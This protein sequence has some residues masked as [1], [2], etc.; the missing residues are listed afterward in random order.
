MKLQYVSTLLIVD[1]QVAQYASDAGNGKSAFNEVDQ[2]LRYRF[3]FD[4]IQDYGRFS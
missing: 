2:C 3:Y 4:A 1:V